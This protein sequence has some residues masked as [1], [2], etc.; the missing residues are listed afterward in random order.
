MNFIYEL[1]KCREII[2]DEYDGSYELVREILSSYKNLEDLS[3]VDHKDLLLLYSATTIMRKKG[4]LDQKI[5]I[6]SLP[7]EEKMKLS[8]TIG[9]I[10]N[11]AQNRE[12]IHHKDDD[13]VEIGMFEALC[14]TFDRRDP[15]T[16]K[17]LNIVTKPSLV[18]DF[19][20][21]CI[22]IMS[23][24]DDE[25]IFKRAAEILDER[26]IGS[27]FGVGSASQILHCLK[28]CIFPV[29]SNKGSAY[30]KFDI[31]LENT[32]KICNY[33][34]NVRKIKNFRDRNF[35][36][37]NYRIF[38]IAP[39]NAVEEKVT[40]YVS[41]DTG[42]TFPLN[43]IIYGPPGTGKTYHTIKYAVEIVENRILDSD[44][45]YSEI[46]RRYDEYALKGR[47]KFTTFHQSF[48]YEDFVEGIKPMIVDRYGKETISANS[49]THMVYLT[50]D[51]VFKKICLL[52]RKNPTL[53]YVMI[54]D[55]INRGNIS[56]I[57][58]ELITLIE[59]TK[60]G[61]EAA[62]PYSGEMFS[63]P[64]NLYI[65]GTMNT[66]DRSIAILDT[67]L[68]RRFDFAEMLPE[69]DL[70]TRDCD[71]VDLQEMLTAMNQRIEYYYD[72]E[73]TIGHAYFMENGVSINS[74]EKLRKIF[75][76]RIIPLMQEYF[77]DD[78][79]KIML[80]LND[81]KKHRFIRELDTRYIKDPRRRNLCIGDIDSLEIGDFIN[82][83][84][85]IYG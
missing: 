28:P 12:Y 54:I 72:R 41:I 10:W 60:R 56:R 19:F 50:K 62:L 47:I 23:M 61:M 1:S 30:D 65:I 78:Y 43:R 4:Y 14:W 75:K 66:A 57:F 2:P 63:V 38:D 68:R 84:G 83:Y 67:A 33:I 27:G 73:H 26:Y 46:R 11:K 39:E 69:P 29:L 55:E 44:E 20:A 71:A 9:K 13:L 32:D 79:E 40:S 53:N 35:R 85:G 24:N 82:I 74:V 18:K 58:G 17:R 3:L 76:S 42:I 52:A 6:S 59:D 5:K 25:A 64:P 31:G 36:F 34:D 7:A 37:K 70:L 51:G 8:D 48:G 80:I 49:E 15:K 21:M 16:G 81:E 45:N 77:F 22:D